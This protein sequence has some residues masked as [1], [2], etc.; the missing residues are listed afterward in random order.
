MAS[1]SSST[2]INKM[3]TVYKSI[4]KDSKILGLD[5]GD[6]AL[7]LELHG[8]KKIPLFSSLSVCHLF[9]MP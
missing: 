3:E 9:I 1:P 4:L 6:T 8:D 5:W 7:D 2:A